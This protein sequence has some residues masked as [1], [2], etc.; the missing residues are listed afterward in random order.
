ME[1][2]KQ[3]KAR[4]VSELVVSGAFHSPLMADALDKLTEALDQLE[5]RTPIIPVYT[6][7]AAQP[8]TDPAVIRDLLKKQLLFPV[9]WQNLIQN[10]IKDGI[11]SFYELGPGKVLQNLLKRIDAGIPCAAVGRKE[12][13]HI[14]N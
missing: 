8:A 1:L 12:D 2:A 13:L 4:L 7:V 3:K 11:T 10:M 6:N 5:I 14:F 9:R